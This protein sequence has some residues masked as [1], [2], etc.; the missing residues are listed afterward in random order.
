MKQRLSQ[1]RIPMLMLVVIIWLDWLM[2]RNVVATVMFGG[3]AA[4]LLLFRRDLI[5]ALRME[6]VLRTTPLTLRVIGAALPGL[7]YFLLRGQ[8]ESGAGFVVTVTTLACVTG[9]AV[10]GDALDAMLGGWYRLRDRL[11]S[12]RVRIGLLVAVPIILGFAVVHGSLIDLPAL[13]GAPT[14]NPQLS[15]DIPGR[16]ALA[17]ALSV[18]LTW[19]LAREK[20]A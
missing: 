19:L 20:R 6:H 11:L 15:T 14:L 7:A 5:G 10:L 4:A 18:I 16:F 9:L 13:V 1:A 8:G 2:Y 17:A 12:R 3:I